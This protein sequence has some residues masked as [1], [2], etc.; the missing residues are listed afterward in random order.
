[1]RVVLVFSKFAFICNIAFLAF[2][3]FRWLEKRKPAATPADIVIPVPFIKEL[4][5]ILGFTA[6]FINL[7][8]NVVYLIFLL[9]GTFKQLPQRLSMANALFLLLQ[10]F[11]FFFI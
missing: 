11:Y 2:A 10:F 6:I 7:I 1:M 5:I 4:I 8:I 9:S 3:F